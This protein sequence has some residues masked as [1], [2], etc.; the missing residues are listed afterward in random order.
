MTT[1]ITT[2]INHDDPKQEFLWHQL[3]QKYLGASEVPIFLGHGYSNQTAWGCW[4]SK[5][6]DVPEDILV[7]DEPDHLWF[8]RRLQEVIG[9]AASMRLGL[10]FYPGV[11]HWG[12]QELGLG[13]TID[14]S[15][16]NDREQVVIME[17]KNRT[18]WA[19]AD[20]TD[21]D[22]P[23][24]HD[25]IQ[26]AGQLLLAERSGFHLADTHY[27]VACVDGSE[28]RSWPVSLDQA[29]QLWP[30]IKEAGREFWR[31]VD[32]GIE[33]EP[34]PIDLPEWL[35]VRGT[36]L[37]DDIN[38]VDDPELE[39]MLAD[40]MAAGQQRL[41]YEKAEQDLKAKL[42]V[43]LGDYRIT[44]AGRM[45]CKQNRIL[46]KES[47]SVRKE[48]IQLRLTVNKKPEAAP[49]DTAAGDGDLPTIAAG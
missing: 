46:M 23:L 47:T 3:R 10:E 1:V 20:T 38:E 44:D 28:L 7:H 30:Q 12:D 13:A 6:V 25:G 17:A 37:V 34:S 16:E 18:S 48:H 31:M 36:G 21:A 29:S 33:P 22:T 4:H 35:K 26:L 9:E 11:V 5:R 39:Q 8:G 45:V 41:M 14:F 2:P 40:F 19:L 32:K 49:I 27:I 24:A 42:A 43:R 15:C